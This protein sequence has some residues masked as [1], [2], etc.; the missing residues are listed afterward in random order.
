MTR[1]PSPR[2][3]LAT[4]PPRLP[5]ADMRAI[6]PLPKQADPELQTVEH[7]AWRDAVLLQAGHA[8]QGCGHTGVRLFADH[9]IER[10]DGGRLLD[11]ANGQALCA[12]CHTKKT[13]QA[14]A[15][16]LKR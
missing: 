7:R 1:K 5:T 10:R 3:R 14:R 8:C 9:I 16:R 2:S 13:V 15:D 6:K 11:P 12:S 4:L